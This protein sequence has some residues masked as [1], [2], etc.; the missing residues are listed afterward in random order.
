ML[1]HCHTLAQKEGKKM[2][3]ILVVD[4][5]KAVRKM[6]KYFLDMHHY[7]IIEA[8]NGLEAFECYKNSSPDLVITDTNMPKMDGPQL[9][10]KILAINPNQPVLMMSGNGKSPEWKGPFIEK[11][12][13]LAKLLLI[14]EHAL[15]SRPD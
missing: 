15:A 3:R 11:P 2:P 4:D 12:F 10:E 13:A 5:E 7:K 8:G 9:A 6:L 1:Y 14:V